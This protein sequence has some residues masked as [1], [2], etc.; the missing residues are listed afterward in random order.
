[1][2][3]K[4]K[5]ENDTK[6]E[7]NEEKCFQLAVDAAHKRGGDTD[8]ILSYLNGQNIDTRS[9]KDRPDL[10]RLCTNSKHEEVV[11]GIEH[12]CVNL[13]EKNLWRTYGKLMKKD[14]K[15]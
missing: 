1:M 2:S 3:T 14:I 13:W 9:K 15:N 6:K 10:I 7:A 11:V 12:F 8:K 4:S 5:S